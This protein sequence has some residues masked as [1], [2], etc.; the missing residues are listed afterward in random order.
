MKNNKREM[1]R[2]VITTRNGNE[3]YVAD[4]SLQLLLVAACTHGILMHYTS[5][6]QG[7]NPLLN[8]LSVVFSKSPHIIPSPFSQQGQ[9]QLSLDPQQ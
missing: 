2:R 3:V 7:Q 6:S 8:Q 1:S 9:E 5:N 4:Q